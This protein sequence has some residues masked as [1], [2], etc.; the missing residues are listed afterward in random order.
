M[1]GRSRLGFGSL[2]FLGLWLFGLS[3]LVQNRVHISFISPFLQILKFLCGDVK[4]EV[5]QKWR[6]SERPQNIFW[7]LT[8]LSANGEVPSN[9][10]GIGCQGRVSMRRA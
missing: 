2:E 9:Q 7:D 6:S 10:D 8:T 4:H 1:K 5:S 3:R